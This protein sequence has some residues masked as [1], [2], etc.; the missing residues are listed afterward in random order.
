M[1]SNWLIHC[2]TINGPI[3]TTNYGFAHMFSFLYRLDSYVFCQKRSIHLC[4]SDNS[5]NRCRFVF[6]STQFYLTMHEMMIVYWFRKMFHMNISSFCQI[7][8]IF[9]K[10]FS[11]FSKCIVTLLVK[12]LNSNTLMNTKNPLNFRPDNSLTDLCE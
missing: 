10:I 6:Q 12:R 7:N 8:S 5:W 1:L 4:R 11:I 3:W 2:W 9:S